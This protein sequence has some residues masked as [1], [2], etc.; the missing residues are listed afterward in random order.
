MAEF[1]FDFPYSSQRMPVLA[2]NVVATSQPVAA[3]AGLRMML[4][5]GNAIDAALA[6]AIALTVVEPTS[7][8]I[9]ADAFAILW[10]GSKLHALNASGR[11][12]SSWNAD[13][14]RQHFNEMPLRGWSSVTVPGAVSAWVELSSRFGKLP[15]EQLFAPAIEYARDGFL[16]SPITAWAW[17]RSVEIFA[18]GEFESFR[19]TFAPAGRALRAG[20]K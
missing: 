6:C 12:P 3:Q 13:W 11:S 19:R 1:S 8:G 16:V 7:N 9:G 14:Y 18:G 20:E 15:F 2:R 4:A 5:G 17:Q 10:D